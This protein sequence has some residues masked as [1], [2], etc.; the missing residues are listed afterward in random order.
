MNSLKILPAIML[1]KNRK[2]RK[3]ISSV[4]YWIVS[5]FIKCVAQVVSFHLQNFDC[6]EKKKKAL[7]FCK[8]MKKIAFYELVKNIRFSIKYFGVFPKLNE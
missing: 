5:I 3:R 6:F 7:V 8:I 4:I 2:K 1:K